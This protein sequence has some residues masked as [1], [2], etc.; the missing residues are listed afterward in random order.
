MKNRNKVKEDAQSAVQ[1]QR[2]A[3]DSNDRAAKK[4]HASQSGI[5]TAWYQD[6]LEKRHS[7]RVGLLQKLLMGS[8][9]S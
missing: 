3:R 4:F 8:R 5:A 7:Q 1:H 6:G 9:K 2:L